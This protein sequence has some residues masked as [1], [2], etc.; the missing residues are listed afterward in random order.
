MMRFIVWLFVLAGFGALLS[1]AQEPRGTI[2]GTATD[3]SG[4]IVVGAKVTITNVDTGVA[5]ETATNTAG[6]YR[7]LFLNPG[8][9]RIEA[10]QPGFKNFVRDN[11]LLQVNQATMIDVSLAIG[12]RAEAIT[13]S[14][15]AVLL[16]TE[17][18]DR[19]V[20]I[21]RVVTSLP[22]NL[23]NPVLMISLSTGVARTTP[24]NN[25]PSVFRQRDL[26]VVC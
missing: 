17:K 10:Q 20:V 23:R 12:A 26:A 5:F 25:A 24:G 7:F 3:T 1:V 15:D 4:A 18:V 19:G 13:V 14:T 21:D 8:K 6:V 16:D 2:S 11:I 9:Y 22:L